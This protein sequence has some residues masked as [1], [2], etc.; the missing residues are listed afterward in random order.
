MSLEGLKRNGHHLELGAFPC[1]GEYGI[2]SIAP[3]QLDERLQWIRFNHA[4]SLPQSERKNYGVHFFMDDYLFERAWRDPPR[5]A[6]F[7][8]D[9]AAVMSPDF[10][11]FM[12]YPKA[13]QVYNHWRKH[14]LGAYWQNM[15]IRVIPS[16]SWAD[17]ASFAWCFD[18]EPTKS[19]IALSSVG[20]Q[21]GKANKQA[22]LEGFIQ[23][24]DSLN[25][26][27]LIIFGTVPKECAELTADKC[28][29]LESHPPF[30]ETFTKEL[31]FC[32]KER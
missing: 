21:K 25:P 13:V 30:Y 24:L 31:A 29:I 4:L 26:T 27:K 14:Q 23:M 20:T 15:G 16:V 11:L 5:Y 18:G 6:L 17:D 10:S 12:D 22:F 28:I 32:T 19:T 1:V 7:L 3:V 9:F 2:P 8:R